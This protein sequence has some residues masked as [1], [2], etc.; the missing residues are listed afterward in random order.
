MNAPLP[1]ALPRREFLQLAAATTA[2]TA[3][4]APRAVAAATPAT[5]EIV[6]THVSLGDWPFRKIP[7]AEPASLVA[8]L[9]AA[10]VTQA[11][12]GSL[13]ALLHK[14]ISAVNG[15]LVAEC[16]RT[17]GGLLV[18]FG[19]LNPSLPG[20]E[21]EL[22]RCAEVHRMP[23]IRLHPN[24]HGYTLRDPVFEQVLAA[25]TARRLLV[26]IAVIMEDERT[27]HPLVNVPATD[28][29]P[30]GPLLKRH[31]RARVQLL[32]AFR[33]LR[34]APLLGLAAQGVRFEIATLD[35]LEGVALLLRQFPADRLCFGSYAPVFYFEAATLKLRESIL[36]PAQLLALTAGNARSFL[37]S[38]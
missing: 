32:N 6:D 35:G 21:E 17:G 30:L 26:Q 10:G 28:T 19:A 25:A 7:G 29:A 13:D 1:R 14:D 24:Y 36:T 34:G 33:T 27:L 23:G 11:W 15:R 12:T 18:P 20:W 5:P 3:L 9:R 8:R 2:V 4:P 16:R 22:R 31:P 37:A 38:G